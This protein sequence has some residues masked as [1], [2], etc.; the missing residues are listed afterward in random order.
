MQNNYLVWFCEYRRKKNRLEFLQSQDTDKKDIKDETYFCTSLSLDLHM[1]FRNNIRNVRFSK[2]FW[3]IL[4]SF[5]DLLSKSTFQ[6]IATRHNYTLQ[7]VKQLFFAKFIE[8]CMYLDQIQL[9]IQLARSYQIHIM[10]H[11]VALLKWRY[12]NGTIFIFEIVTP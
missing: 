9:Q 2:G 1:L 7:H 6:E 4:S 8:A 10:D 11:D 5:I 12:Q 3:A